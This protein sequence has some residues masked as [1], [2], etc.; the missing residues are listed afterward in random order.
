MSRYFSFYAATLIVSCMG[1][2]LWAQSALFVRQ[3]NLSQNSIETYVWLDP[4]H[5]LPALDDE[6]DIEGTLLST[7]C[8]SSVYTGE[9]SSNLNSNITI[10]P[11]SGMISIVGL[12]EGGVTSTWPDQ[13][14]KGMLEQS[15][16]TV[17]ELVCQGLP[18]DATFTL[19]A[20]IQVN[21]SGYLANGPM[22]T[23][24]YGIY[25]G[26]GPNKTK[27]MSVSINFGSITM[28]SPNK[29]YHGPLG[30]SGAYAV[31][32]TIVDDAK[33]GDVFTVI[34]SQYAEGKMTQFESSALEW[35]I[36]VTSTQNP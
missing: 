28:S 26:S 24:S 11:T 6:D 31:S 14:G 10:G 34:G 15:G 5:G 2:S 35:Q 36:N 19:N 22:C 7:T 32:D 29:S 20:E 30:S 17:H 8:A 23:G 16:K 12:T 9:A 1:S 25:S 27:L 33:C 3:P 21:W 4:G 18:P 13:W